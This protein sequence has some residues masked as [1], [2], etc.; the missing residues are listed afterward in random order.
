MTVSI[1][2][3]SLYCYTGYFMHFKTLFLKVVHRLH[4]TANG[5]YDLKNK[6]VNKQ[7]RAHEVLPMSH[8]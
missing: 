5:I 4:Q 3:F 2:W 6:Q 7:W 1:N 8:N